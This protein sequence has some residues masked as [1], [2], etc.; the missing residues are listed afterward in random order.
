[1]NVT[2]RTVA[3]AE[4]AE[5]VAAVRLLEGTNSANTRAVRELAQI[6]T[7]PDTGLVKRLD[8]VA[9][10]NTTNRVV[11]LLLVLALLFGGW[12]F[13]KFKE[14]QDCRA[15]YTDTFLALEKKKVGGQI[16]GI[17]DILSRDPVGGVNKFKAAS[18]HYLDGIAVIDRC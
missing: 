17:D 9:R 4:L 1:V 2:G 6:I 18:Q 12:A 13:W 7:D 11:S 8:V 14:Y 3:D 15:R 5:L 10:R 16:A